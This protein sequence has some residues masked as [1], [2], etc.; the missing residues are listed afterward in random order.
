MKIL[1][2]FY[3][4][5]NML[6]GLRQIIGGFFKSPWDCIGNADRQE[7]GVVTGWENILENIFDWF[8]KYLVL[9]I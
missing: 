5:P 4:F 9:K 8:R 1:I 2:V 7:E 3:R 6:Y